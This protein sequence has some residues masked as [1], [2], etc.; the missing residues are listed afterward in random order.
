MLV[1]SRSVQIP[2]REFHWQ[3]A[4]SGGPGGQHV[5]KTSTKAVLRWN[6]RDSPSLPDGVRRRFLETYRT[7]INQDGEL[8]LTSD[9]YRSQSQNI[10]DCLERLRTMLLAVLHPPK[11]RRATRPTRASKERR[12][13]QKK[14]TG[15]KKRLRKKPR[16]DD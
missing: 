5:N 16:L 13:T 7:R 10:E 9:Q 11:K 15:S 8:L 6:T 2:E 3:F 1:I 12:L 14:Q 4:R